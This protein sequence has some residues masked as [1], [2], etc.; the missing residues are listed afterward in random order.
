MQE[1]YSVFKIPNMEPVKADDFESTKQMSDIYIELNQIAEE[2]EE[3][4]LRNC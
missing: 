4:R 1:N 2:L 3:C